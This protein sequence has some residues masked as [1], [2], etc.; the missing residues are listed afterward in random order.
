MS[1]KARD[2]VVTSGRLIR[3]VQASRAPPD[4]E[5]PP[6]FHGDYSLYSTESE[7]QVTSIHRGLDQ[8]AALLSGILKADEA[9]S[10]GLQRTAKKVTTKPRSSTFQGKKT[11]KK[12]P[13]KIGICVCV[14]VEA[15]PSRCRT[16]KGGA[17]KSRG[18]TP[19]GKMSTKKPA[20]KTADPQSS[21]RC[22]PGSL[23]AAAHDFTPPAAHS[24]VKLHPPRKPTLPSPSPSPRHQTSPHLSA[25]DPPPQ[26]ANA[27]PQHD[28]NLDERLLSCLEQTAGGSDIQ[29]AA[30]S[31][32]PHFS[33]VKNQHEK[34][35]ELQKQQIL[36]YS[37]E[38]SFQKQLV[39][40]Q[41][42]LQEL[43]DDLIELRK[44]LQDTQNQLRDTEAEKALMKTE[45]EAVRNRLLESE[46]EKSELASVAQQ[47]L[48]E[49]ENLQRL[50]QRQT[51]VDYL[52]VQSSL[53]LTKQYFGQEDSAVVSTDRIKEYLISLK[54]MEPTHTENVRVAAERDENTPELKVDGLKRRDKPVETLTLHQDHHQHPSSE[55]LLPRGRQLLNC[56]V[57]SVWSNWSARSES[58]FNTRD[59]AAFRDG[60]E[61]LDAS[62]ASLQ[63][64]IQL[65][66]RN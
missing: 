62:I 14:C 38:P 12:F 46:R 63:K 2:K 59:E 65:D 56:D 40:V 25:D 47:R 57:E 60:L 4:P 8:C 9:A 26:G 17:A 15:S 33:S 41:S 64:T 6:W 53:S 35:E 45:L 24:G 54:Q 23:A 28:Q 21:E 20:V 5:P 32:N 36:P 58:T 55:D 13:T 39:I 29:T 52:D 44:A 18:S 7:D 48:K 30:D 31:L 43:Q 16:V 27:V 61:A 37:E 51:S 22:Q 11:V 3:K 1:R 50:L 42:S 66:L 10:T 19:Q 49:I 34:V